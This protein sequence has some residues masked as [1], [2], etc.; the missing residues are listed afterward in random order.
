MVLFAP[1]QGVATRCSAPAF[2]AS[3]SGQVLLRLFC[4]LP[5]EEEV[6][7]EGQLPLDGEVHHL[8]AEV[9]EPGL[10]YFDFNDTRAGWR[11]QAEPGVPCTILLQRGRGFRHA[12]HMQP[13]YFY[14]P[15]G[16]RTLYYYWKG[17]PHGLYNPDGERVKRV[18]DS[19]V[20]VKVK[21]PERMDGRLWHF[22]RLA[23]GH[24]YFFN[25]PN[26]LAGS[27]AALL[28]PRELAERDGLTRQ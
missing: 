17:R 9:P 15:K 24:L 16:T 18:T 3:L 23:L 20:F 11:I 28:L 21:V 12:G 22:R 7:V 26:C 27:P 5:R 2:A 14:V 6:I 25:A 10:Y 13:M 1:I 8:Q 19:G 4:R